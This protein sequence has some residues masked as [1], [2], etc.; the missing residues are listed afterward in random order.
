MIFNIK[1]NGENVTD[2]MGRSRLISGSVYSIAYGWD[3]SKEMNGWWIFYIYDEI[4]KYTNETF[5]FELEIKN[6]ESLRDY[7]LESL[8]R[9]D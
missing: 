4:G 2:E 8:L 7:N 1:Y 6:I 9:T 5:G 3:I